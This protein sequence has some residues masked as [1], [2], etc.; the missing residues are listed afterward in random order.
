MIKINGVKI[1]D[2]GFYINLDKR[3]DRKEK[4]ESQLKDF[5]VEG[6]QRFSAVNDLGSGP[7]NCKQ[8][9]YRVYEEF[10]KTDGEVLLVLEDDCLFL[11]YFNEHSLNII[12]DI[13][14]VEW[15][16]FWLG[17]RNRR[18]PQLYKHNT[19]K[20]SSVSH[21]QSYLIKR[22]FCKYILDN[23]PITIH[24]HIAIDELLCLSI[25][26]CEVTSNPDKF[27]FYQLDNPLN[28]LPIIFTSLCYEKPLSTQYP[29]YS[30]LQNMEIDYEDYIKNSHPS[31]P[32]N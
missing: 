25:Y 19:Y 21:A 1:A 31:N 24:N 3:V 22:D 18:S 27:N 8:S 28:D 4:I 30:D 10:L 6:M 2:T 13:N 5:N 20:V 9:H 7:L 15:D 32:L 14:S 12:N 16:L 26:G 29:S 11:D 17:C 23:Y